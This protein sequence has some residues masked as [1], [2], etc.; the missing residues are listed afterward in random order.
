MVLAAVS[1]LDPPPVRSKDAK[2]FANAISVEESI[3]LCICQGF[4]EFIHDVV[5]QIENVV[6]EQF[7]GYFNSNVK[8]VGIKVNLVEGGVTECERT[9][10]LNPRGC[11]SGSG[12]VY[13]ALT[14]GLYDGGIPRNMFSLSVPQSDEC[15][16][17]RGEVTTVSIHAL[18]QNILT[19]R[20]LERRCVLSLT[21]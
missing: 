15:R 12:N 16:T 17:P 13:F 8:L 5:L 21:L 9:T 6:I 10:L 19:L 4:G 7:L 18:L 20:K 2:G 3:L 14:A 11:G 1:N